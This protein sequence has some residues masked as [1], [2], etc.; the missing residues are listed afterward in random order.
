[1]ISLFITLFIL[2]S[3]PEDQSCKLVLQRMTTELA[4]KPST[5][6]EIEGPMTNQF[7][8]NVSPFTSVGELFK[9]T[10]SRRIKL[11]KDYT[12]WVARNFPE[13]GPLNIPF[14]KV[15]VKFKKELIKKLHQLFLFSGSFDAGVRKVPRV[16]I[17][18]DPKLNFQREIKFRGK[19]Y[20]EG[21][22]VLPTDG[23]LKTEFEYMNHRS[24]KDFDGAELH[25]T[26]G[27]R[28]R[29]LVE[30]AWT[31]MEGL[32]MATL[33]VHAHLVSHRPIELSPIQVIQYSDFY[34]RVELL[35]EMNSLLN[36]DEYIGLRRNGSLFRVF[37]APLNRYY[38][39][40]AIRHFKDRFYNT[41]FSAGIGDRLKHSYVAARDDSKY[42]LGYWEH[43]KSEV[44]WGLEYRT[45]DH[46][47]APETMGNILDSIQYAMETKDFGMSE[48]TIKAWLKQQGWFKKRA[49][50]K[51]WF[52]GF[53]PA[54]VMSTHSEIK[55]ILSWKDWYFLRKI[56]KRNQELK[57]LIHDWSNDPM[58]FQNPEA[59]ARILQEQKNA[60]KLILENQSP[61]PDVM[62][63]FMLK[64]GIFEETAASLGMKVIIESNTE[65]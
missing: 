59:Q 64:S 8:E 26:A 29:E 13:L 27:K 46:T 9:K 52:N 33:S 7:W 39:N 15:H 24:H 60:L 61:I 44:R 30:D 43:E 62:K 48:Q 10:D 49:L 22:V 18:S 34:R 4:K 58:F 23:D 1:M 54:L 38:F 50:V 11:S 35:A 57:M 21:E 53:W 6:V 31:I 17:L 40:H 36:S 63:N 32:H 3:L 55:K 28:A 2:Q 16:Q 45:V 37:F 5:G 14:G 41:F 19:N 51:T 25:L 47:V 42:P 12:E 20:A 56:S 65:Q